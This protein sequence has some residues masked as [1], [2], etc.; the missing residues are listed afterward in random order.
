MISDPWFHPI[1]FLEYGSVAQNP[2]AWVD[3]TLPQIRSLTL[4]YDGDIYFPSVQGDSLETLTPRRSMVDIRSAR[5]IQMPD[6]WFYVT[7]KRG[8]FQCDQLEG[9]FRCLTFVLS[10]AP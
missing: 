7:S 5:I 4:V 9:L 2:D 8:D 1:T 3:L 10:P 6:E